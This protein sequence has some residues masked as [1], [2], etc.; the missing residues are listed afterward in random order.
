MREKNVSGGFGMLESSSVDS[1]SSNKFL[2]WWSWHWWLLREKLFSL[3]VFWVH[4]PPP[5]LASNFYPFFFLHK[6]HFVWGWPINMA[7]LRAISATLREN[8]ECSSLP[9]LLEFVLAW[10]VFNSFSGNLPPNLRRSR[11][12]DFR[13]VQPFCCLLGKFGWNCENLPAGWETRQK[14]LRFKLWKY[15]STLDV[16]SK[17][18][19][20]NCV[21]SIHQRLK[22]GKRSIL[23]LPE[24]TIFA[25]KWN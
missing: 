4:P 10:C 18:K 9:P 25:G 23:E 22:R 20:R 2:V 1:V 21:V 19:L 24:M 6:C 17:Q 15:I 3:E 13:V 5:W 14:F 12:S 16:V 11:H 7:F 8:R